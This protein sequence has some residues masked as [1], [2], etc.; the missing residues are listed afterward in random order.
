MTCA[1]CGAAKTA[2]VERERAVGL[3]VERVAVVVDKASERVDHVL[4]QVVSRYDLDRPEQGS[5]TE[6]ARRFIV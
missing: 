5:T 3:L 6:I 2:P 1:R 4:S